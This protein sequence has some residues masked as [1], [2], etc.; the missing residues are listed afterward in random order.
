M[1][2]ADPI[3]RIIDLCRWFGGRP[4]GMPPSTEFLGDLYQH[5]CEAARKGRALVQTPDFVREFIL[6]K[7]LALVIDRQGPAAARM[8]DPS[9]GCGHFLV[10][11]FRMIFDSLNA[12]PDEDL[13][14]ILEADG[15]ADP[16]RTLVDCTV[17]AALDRV[18]GVDLDP[19]CVAIGRARLMFEAWG[20][21]ASWR[22]ADRT[23][24][25][26]F[27]PRV[28]EGDSLL[29]GRPMPGDDERFGPWPYDV[30]AVRA[31]LAPGQYT[32]V[33]GNPPYIVCRDAKLSEAYRERYPTCHRQYSLGVPFTELC[34]GL[35]VSGHPAMVNRTGS[36]PA[37]P[38]ATRSAGATRGLQETLF[39][40]GDREIP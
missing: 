8:I 37:K 35:A 30:G 10:D 4:A 13:V 39:A 34:F 29:H 31:A 12:L 5:H 1:T 15:F 28:Y 20:A 40:F 7:T 24:R 21:S 32:A 25:G 11:G 22:Q 26:D 23:R 16:A 6:E 18:V 38:R 14:P 17:Q 3:S 2:T 19:A 36:G 33:V 9:C 27:R